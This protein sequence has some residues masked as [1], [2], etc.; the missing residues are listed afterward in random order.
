MISGDNITVTGVDSVFNGSFVI[1]STTSTTISYAKTNANVASTSATGS[2]A[3]ARCNNFNGSFRVT[4]VTSTTL[5][6]ALINANVASTTASGSVVANMSSDYIENLSVVSCKQALGGGLWLSFAATPGGNVGGTSTGSNNH[7]QF[8]WRGGYAQGAP[9]AGPISKTGCS[10]TLNTSVPGGGHGT[11]NST[12]T[13]ADTS[14]LSTGMFV[15]ATISGSDYYVGTIKTV[16]SGSI[17]LDKYPFMWNSNFTSNATSTATGHLG[18]TTYTGSYTTSGGGAGA[19][20]KF[21]SLRP[22]EH[23]HGRGTLTI[24]STSTTPIQSGQAGTSGE[25]HW[26][27]ANVTDWYVYRASD[28][29][30]IGKIASVTDNDTATLLDSSGWKLTGENYI[31]RQIQPT[32]LAGS[33][34]AAFSSIVFNRLATNFAGLYTAVYAGYQWFGNMANQ[35]KDINRVVFSASHDKEAVDLS[36]NA[37]DSIIF[38]G[39]SQFRGMAAS[40]T[41]LLVFLEDRTYILR[42]NDRTNFS[43]EQLYPEGCLCASSI[44][45]YAGGVFWAGKSGIL[46]YDGGSVRNITKDNLG[47][48][49]TDAL[50]VFNPELDRVIGFIHKNNLV[51]TFT[52]F[53]SPFTPI[54]YEPLYAADWA[55]LVTQGRSWAELDPT[56]TYADKDP[57]TQNN[58]PLYW[59]EQR[60]NDP[61]SSG[62]TGLSFK[63]DDGSPSLWQTTSNI[64][65]YGPLR[66]NTS[67]TFSIYLPTNAITTFGNMDFRGV[68]NIETTNGLKTLVGVNSVENSLLCARL[69][70]VHP[71]YDINTN[72]QDAYTIEKINIPNSSL[73]KGPDFYLQTKNYT[74]G[75]PILRKWFQRIMLSMLLYDG[76]LRLDLVDDDDNDAVDVAKKKHQYWELFTEEGYDWDYL[77]KGEGYDY[78]VVFSKLTS[79]NKS[80]WDNVEKT[81]TLWSNLFTADFN[82]YKMRTSWR[83]PTLGFRLYQ[84]NNYKKVNS[85]VVTRPDR[86]E[87]QSFS[88]GFKALREG[89]Q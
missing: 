47:L 52:S 17:V 6:Y 87:I 55:S 25:G 51:M 60:L 70:D 84:L 43:V 71:V 15:Y 76:C 64:Y 18:D 13:V 14:N 26:Q 73:I 20:L 88:I 39:K 53:K 77:G 61:A 34:S 9:A 79:P 74:M 40:S 59:D 31:M 1:T 81:L 38:P 41:G 54:R 35:D 75:N 86:I 46:F 68:A 8:Y 62:A 63:W 24:D 2:V 65:K 28:N 16:L 66:K 12:V 67:I 22:Y 82:R 80:I 32:V 44:V 27:S 78:G 58:T 10:F 85:G 49:Y 50:D 69:I 36:T 89:R 4:D 57:I 72:G 56:F 21:T 5:S 45:E 48:Y 19:T 23:M 30:F 7:Y 33:T 83:Q 42:G 37:A 3:C 11:L 29:A